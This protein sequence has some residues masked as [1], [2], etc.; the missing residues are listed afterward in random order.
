MK[1]LTIISGKGGTGKTTVVA[2]FAALAA[3]AV[4]ADAD[5]DAA[6]LHLLLAPEIK[7]TNDF[8][9]GFSALIDAGQCNRCAVCVAV[10]RYGA[11]SPELKVDPILCEGCGVCVD[12]CLIHAIYEDREM[13]G[14]WF[15]SSTRFGPLIH[16]ALFAGRDNSGKL[17]A[18]V[19]KRAVEVAQSEG[20]DLVIIDGPPGIGCPV[21]SSLTGV[22][23]ILAVTEPSP[24]GLHDLDR[25][26]DLCAHFGIPTMICVNKADLAP[27]LTECIVRHA[28]SKGAT[29]AGLLPYDPAAVQAMMAGL[30]VVQ[31]APGPLA[32]ALRRLWIAV[33]EHLSQ[34]TPQEEK[35][36]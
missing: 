29:A 34:Q 1:Q 14:R 3:G 10:C 4:L 20:R 21:I 11:I 28:Q 22:D 35:E 7:K 27:E 24:S 9:G 31:M 32:E 5:V 12:R 30:P 18:Q 19:R 13:A 15:E 25:V 2:S 8:L 36:E 6:D 23:L 16:A 33:S 17:V 26:L